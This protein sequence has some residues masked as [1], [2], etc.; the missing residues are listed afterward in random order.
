MLGSRT[1]T[2]PDR[3]WVVLA[4]LLL[5]LLAVVSATLGPESVPIMMVGAAA[6]IAIA[7]RPVWGVA[8]I[9]AMLLIQYGSGRLHPRE[10]E[11]AV[12]ALLPGGAGLVTINNT[13]GAFLAVLLVYHIYRSGDWSFL[14]NRQVQIM[15]LIT[16]AFMVSSLLHP[17]D[18][19]ARAQLGLRTPAQSPMRVIVTRT[20]YLLLFVT[21]VRAPR[22]LRLIIGIFLALSLATALSASV[23]ALTGGVAWKERL[24]TY[25]AGG[26]GVLIEAGAN[27]NRL[28]MI[29][30]LALIFVWE[31][32]RTEV[33]RFGAWVIAPIVLLLVTTVF[34]S[35]SRGGVVGLTFAA[36]LLFAR[37]RSRGRIVYG[38]AVACVAVAIAIEFV[39]EQNWERLTDLPG[40]TYE[41]SARGG[42]LGRRQYSLGI[43]MRLSSQHPF[44]GVGLGNWEHARF[45]VDPLRS[46]G[47]PHNSYLLA[48]SEGGIVT[49]SLYL[50]LFA[51]TLRQL[52]RLENDADAMERARRDGVEW[53]VTGTRIALTAF[54]VFSLFA[55]LWELIFLYLL[56]GLAAVLADAYG[57]RE[58]RL[59][60]A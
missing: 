34:L 27:P 32:A 46:I 35:A 42:S 39:P 20:L 37:Q 53:L 3:T 4:L 58:G 45:E 7:A 24:P 25:R 5:L 18:L 31:Y 11:A 59:I 2:A 57:R 16:A 54:L 23:D 41:T 47:V 8:T 52:W 30:T 28:A 17:I 22:D 43:A 1:A 44:F 51:V 49:L 60:Y 13:L 36:L 55:D 12:A 48:L 9:L 50:V 29:C 19:E 33:R 26:T 14:R 38:L 56:V 10:G 40:L 6:L 15:L 21:F